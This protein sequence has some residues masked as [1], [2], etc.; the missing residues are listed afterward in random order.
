MSRRLTWSAAILSWVVFGATPAHAIPPAEELCA[1][2]GGTWNP[3]G[4]GCGPATCD[5]PNPSGDTGICPEVCVPLCECPASAPLWDDAKGCIAADECP[6][7]PPLDPDQ[8]L[9]AQTGGKWNPCGP[10]CGPP[11]CENV[12]GGSGAG[13]PVQCVPQCNCPA[14]A[15]LWDATQGCIAQDACPPPPPKEL[16]KL[17]GG[18]WAQCGSGCGPATCAD[19]SPGPDCPD[20]CVEQC[21][22]PSSAP[23]WDD[24]TGCIALDACDPA[25][26]P[27]VLAC[28]QTGGAWQDAGEGCA[29]APWCPAA[30]G[31]TCPAAA[32]EKGCRCGEGLVWD[33]AN[34]CVDVATCPLVVDDDGDGVNERDGDCDD[35]NAGIFPGAVDLCDGID[36]DCDGQT[37]ENCEPPPE[38]TLCETTGGTWTDCAKKC[39]VDD[40]ACLNVCRDGC[41]CPPAAPRWHP[42]LGCHPD[43]A[44]LPG[45]AQ[46]PTGEVSGDGKPDEPLVPADAGE[47]TTPEATPSGD[48]GGGNGCA[49]GSNAADGLLVSLLLAVAALVVTGMRRRGHRAA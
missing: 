19:P 27:A 22:C 38:V 29:A 41:T 7:P 1:Q 3:C 30:P 48:S 35:T 39:A 40:S 42:D 8:A 20:A 34:G 37:D 5:N 49:S 47:T 9:C 24:A 21:V 14:D 16:C 26:E 36:N 25:L 32:G 44:A 17:T 31:D 12:G 13:C 4:S 10:P 33:E 46:A 43:D 28:L 15:P 6:T 2:D 18:F 11:T 45:N 23:L